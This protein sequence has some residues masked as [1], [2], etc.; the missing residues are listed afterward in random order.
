MRAALAALLITAL[1]GATP[2]VAQQRRAEVRLEQAMQVEQVRGDLPQAIRLY[3]QILRDHPRERVVAARAL[4][5]IGLCYEALGRGE[6]QRAYERVISDYGDQADEVRQARARLAALQPAGGAVVG[7]GPVA[8]RLLSGDDMDVDNFYTMVPS[9]DG[10]RVAWVDLDVGGLHV[11][12]LATGAEDTVLPGLPA[13]FNWA[14]VWSPDGRRIAFTYGAAQ[15]RGTAIGIVDLVSRT[16]DTVPGSF[17]PWSG[18]YPTLELDLADWSRDGR[19]LLFALRGGTIGVMPAGGGARTMLADSVTGASRA[20]FSPDGRFV[21]YAD[22]PQGAE[23][24][25]VQPVGGGAR[26]QVTSGRFGNVAPMW[27]PD[28]GAIAYVGEGGIW[29]TPV[30]DGT[31]TG[32]ARLAYADR[33][34]TN[35]ARII[36]A[37]AG[38]VYLTHVLDFMVP[39][40]LPV[41]SATGTP[42]PSVERLSPHPDF[43]RTFAW[44][45]DMQRTAFATHAGDLYVYTNDG[46]ARAMYTVSPRQPLSVLEW[47]ADGSEVFASR[48]VAQNG[49]AIVAVNAGTGAVRELARSMP[50][51][52]PEDV[53][54]DGRRLLWYYGA[55]PD[56]VPLGLYVS[57]V[58]QPA[59]RL[60]APLWDA[61]SM[62]IYGAS[63]SPRGDRVAFARGPGQGH[64]GQMTLWVVAVDGTGLRRIAT[65]RTIGTALWYPTG[66]AAVWSPSGR[67]IAVVG[68]LDSTTTVLRVVDVA[69]GEVRGTT[70]LPDPRW[71]RIELGGWSQ[72]ERFI[73][74]AA[75]E[76]RSEYWV[77]EGLLEHRP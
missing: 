74:I 54:A 22:G 10:R 28:G 72:D 73:A 20:S 50:N 21:V 31:P 17:V 34:T 8:R 44:A 1:A 46:A 55:L 14:P 47:S 60:V 11:R 57:A 25:Y 12:D 40:R 53:S 3:Q 48:R 71:Q 59:G 7:R 24:I 4:L 65:M 36:W 42:A 43:I 68:T 51:R 62:Q 37:R 5:H 27:S 67:F 30:A 58:D 33:N 63:L 52:W 39:Y 75:S 66:R 23:Q 70:T 26:R 35:G 13:A 64:S 77:L 76:P 9:P 18:R 38:G 61:D 49:R 41:D 2:A 6:A 16:V 19:V 45:P 56:T 32:A 15:P 69:T 29:V